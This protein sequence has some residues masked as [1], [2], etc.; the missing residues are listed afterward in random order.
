[1]F[2][3]NFEEVVERAGRQYAEA[4]ARLS[5]AESGWAQAQREKAQVQREKARIQQ[6][7]TQ[8][9]QEKARI[10]QKWTQAQEEKGIQR[11]AVLA[12]K[13][14]GFSAEEISLQLGL[15]REEADAM[16]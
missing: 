10:Q 9:Q 1:M 8:A 11:Q 14:A 6:K 5:V 13:K 7:W 16:T 15:S 12:L 2:V 4:M 3:S